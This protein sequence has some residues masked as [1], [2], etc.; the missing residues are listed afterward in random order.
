MPRSTK[1]TH[2]TPREVAAAISRSRRDFLREATGATLAGAF[3][4]T[5][6]GIGEFEESCGVTFGAVRA[7]TK[8]L[9]QTGKTIFPIC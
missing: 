4:L 6:Y 3:G 7:T 8:R 2:A 1:L 5:R 9:I